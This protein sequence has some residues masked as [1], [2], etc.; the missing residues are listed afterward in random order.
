MTWS[1]LWRDGFVFLDFLFIMN[2]DAG[3]ETAVGFGFLTFIFNLMTF[4]ELKIKK[5]QVLVFA[6]EIKNYLRSI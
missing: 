2:K 1:R 5:S 3:F 4:Y 6:L